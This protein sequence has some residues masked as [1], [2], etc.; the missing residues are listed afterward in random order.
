MEKKKL[1][2]YGVGRY[3]EYVRYVFDNDSSFTVIAY[4]IEKT[5][6]KENEFDKLPLYAFEDLKSHF[7]PD[8]CSLFIAVGQNEIRKRIFQDAQKTGFGLVNYISS[9]AN[10]WKNLSLGKNCFIGE[11]STLQPFVEIADNCILFAANIGHHTKIGKNVLVSAMTL[12]GNVE[13]GDNCFLGMNS[14][15]AQNVKLGENTIIGMGCTIS[16][17]TEPNSVYSAKGTSKRKVSYTEVSQRF[18]S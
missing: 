6:L 18:L 14:T 3:A 2:I 15:V 8:C 4:C 16:R 1:I 11:G 5:L 17:D 7:S 12:G 10:T 13:V 9:K